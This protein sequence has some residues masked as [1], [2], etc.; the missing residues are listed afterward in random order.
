MPDEIPEVIWN[1]DKTAGILNLITELN[2][3]LSKSEALRMIKNGGIRLNQKKVEDPSFIVTIRDG[4]VLQ[5]GKRKFVRLK[6][7]R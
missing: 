6:L 1:K 2:M 5:A 3:L 7:E 4:L